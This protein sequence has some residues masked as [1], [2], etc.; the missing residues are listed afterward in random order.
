MKKVVDKN[1]KPHKFYGFGGWLLFYVVAFYF[2]YPIFDYIDLQILLNDKKQ[3]LVVSGEFGDGYIDYYNNL[4]YI[5]AVKLLIGLYVLYLL[6]KK[7]E[8]STIY[9]NLFFLWIMPFVFMFYSLMQY[10]MQVKTTNFMFIFSLIT[11]CINELFIS[12]LLSFYFSFSRR[13]KATYDFGYAKIESNA[14]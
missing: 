14:E 11:N 12:L 1:Q 5:V 9:T 8:R 7:Y 10:E 13:V 4:Q 2:L 3:A 6:I